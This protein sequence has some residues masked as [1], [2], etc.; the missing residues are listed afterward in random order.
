M[1]LLSAR[2]ITAG[3][4]LTV[5]V[6]PGCMEEEPVK[7][8][9]IIIL[10]DDQGWGDMAYYGHPILKTPNFDEMSGSG[11]RFDRF[12]AAAPVSS[13]TRGSIMT[14][15]HPN[16]FGCFTWGHTLRPQEITLAQALKTT[17]YITGHFGKWHLGPV[18]KGSPVNPGASGFHEWLSSP[19]FFEN[20]PILSREGTAIQMKGES[21]MVTVEAAL[22]FISKHKE[23]SAPF[24]A[25]VC[26][27]SPHL[28]HIADELDR[29]LYLDQE[30][31][32]QHFYGEIT[33]MDRAVGKMRE[34]LRNM[35]IA[36][37]TILWYL[38]DNG[39][40]RDL[41]I[42]GGREAKGS[43]YE[44]GLRVPAIL[45]WPAMV[46][47]PLI[48]DVPCNTSDIYPTLL[49]IVGIELNKQPVLDGISLVPLI[50]GN[51]RSR[52]EPMGF[53]Q[54]RP[55]AG[56]RTPSETLMKELLEHQQSGIMEID[57]AMLVLDAGIID[58]IYELDVFPGHAA[59]LDWPYKLHRIQGKQGES[60]NELYDLHLDPMEERDLSDFELDIVHDMNTELEN[61]L[62]SVINSL[63][64]GDYN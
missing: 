11:V 13:P 9:I 7:P 18:Y 15:R 50:E 53:W 33:G 40:L 8:N 31:R 28:P 58:T 47:E 23:S 3:C 46:K 25:F 42:T 39:G 17:G 52:E 54:Y 2:A 38:S 12:Y 55:V 57:S 48:I 64:G 37:N 24:F 49:D 4:C 43:I 35:G 51:M 19:N 30:E 62:L 1:R 29:A 41:G 45:E 6:M 16:R 5:T 63:N 14:G 56:I 59:W 36:D 26:F 44:G 20:D 10:A 34:E 22:E 61:W 21:S 32:F 27:G 60:I